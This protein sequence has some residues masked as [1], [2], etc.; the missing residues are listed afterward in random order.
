M[1]F[2]LVGPDL[3]SNL[4][5]G[6]LAA[7]LKRA[8]HGAVI[9]SFTT[10]ADAAEVLRAARDFDAVGLSLSFQVRAPEFLELAAALKRDRPR[11]PVI[12][13]GHFATCAATELMRDFPALDLVVQHEAEHAIVE[14]AELG[15][16]LLARAKEVVGVVYREGGEIH[17]SPLRRADDALDLLPP[18]DRDGPSRLI[19]GV[20]TA[21]IMGSRGCIRNCDYCCITTLHR[22]APGARFRQRSPENVVAEL[23]DLYHRRGVRQ[24]VF[25]D[26]NF[27][28]PAPQRNLERIARYR[29]AIEGAG[30]R[31]IGLVLK[32]GPQDLDRASL[33][34]LVEMGLIRIFLGIESGSQCGLDSIGRRQTTTDTERAVSLC[35]EVG[36]SSQY[37]MIIFHPD[38]TIE[39]M[40]EDLAFVD[41]HPAHPLNYCRAELYAGTPLERRML[42]EGRALGTY[43]A[44]T[45]RYR[46]PRVARVWLHGKDLFA[47]RCW[48]HDEILGH[49]IRLDH[50][51]TVLEHFYEG[52]SAR[53]VARD[54]HAWQVALNLETAALFRELVIACGDASTDDAPA[55]ARALADLRERELRTRR[56]QLAALCELRARVSRIVEPLI[57]CALAPPAARVVPRRAPRHMAALLLAASMLGCRGLHG[58]EGVA[59]AAPP[60]VDRRLQ[61]D[62]GVAEAAPP[63]IDGTGEQSGAKPPPPAQV[64]LVPTPPVDPT[65]GQQVQGGQGTPPPPPSGGRRRRRRVI[66]P[67]VRVIQDH[68]VAE[69]A[70][71]PYDDRLIRDEGVAEAAPPPIDRLRGRKA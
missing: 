31:D 5:L 64:E 41:R 18:P 70:P 69:A 40:L 21:Y 33:D 3:E 37:T 20:P 52:T 50:Q 35:E 36:I 62:Q 57:E 27:L 58:D 1:R 13:G 32:C 4:S 10:E 30:L 44:R 23:A 63:P 2:L 19:A 68:G 59:E 24:F 42:D 39:S 67:D 46:D 71:P 54:F 53:R 51:I 49:M 22:L 12:A 25:H 43:M 61:G 16:E 11:R 56:V 15:G 65:L 60:P 34:A 26:D 45:Y 38:A 9:A 28:V 47:G 6:Y 55:L 48:G 7:S 66:G 14:L 17:A 29:S 8:G